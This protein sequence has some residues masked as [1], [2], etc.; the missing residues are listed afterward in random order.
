MSNLIQI[1]KQVY[2]VEMALEQFIG[3]D[4]SK[5]KKSSKSFNICCPFHRDEHPSFTIWRETN[6][7]KCWA[8]CG[9]G[10]Q[11]N[12]V[13]KALNLTNKEAIK[14]LS[15]QLN[16]GKEQANYRRDKVER[17]ILNKQLLETFNYRIR[18]TF[19]TL[20]K[21]RSTV[22]MQIQEVIGEGDLDCEYIVHLHHLVPK[23]EGWLE[24]LESKDYKLQ[25]YTLL[26]VQNFFEKGL[27]SWMKTN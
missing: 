10:D 5:V 13:A 27:T 18:E 19:F 21:M 12:L 25:Y 14:V 26:D 22:K 9:G 8:G 7:W 17:L 6:Y 11:I 1:I 20:I 3:I 4:L 16:L 23:L 24:G 15:K 2:T